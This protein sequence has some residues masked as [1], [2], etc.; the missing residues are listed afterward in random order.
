MI[1]TGND[2]VAL[3]ATD[4]DRTSRF[5]FYSRILTRRELDQVAGTALPFST[6]VWLFWSI[7]ESVYKYV[8]RADPRLGFAPLNIPVNRLRRR[9]DYY[10]GMIG[11]GP[12]TLYSRSFLR[13]ETIMTVVSEE[14]EFTHV[15]WGVQGIG[16]SDYA[17]QSASVRTFALQSLSTALPGVALRI[18][19]TPDGPPEVWNN[20]HSLDIPLSLAHHGPYV[21]W[22]YRLPA[23]NSSYR[24]SA[25]N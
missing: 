22:S 2:I 20:E 15:R 11:Y 21:A 12:A 17:S 14:R 4:K 25:A 9:K 16:D 7:K 1:S 18:I 5:R 8:S 3:G 10:E 24:K 13:E 19:K 23:N 6:F